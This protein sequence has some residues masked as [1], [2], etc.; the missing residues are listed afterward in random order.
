MVCGRA[1]RHPAAAQHPSGCTA[2]GRV[3]RPG[4]R[5][6]GADHPGDRDDDLL[7]RLAPRRRLASRREM[8]SPTTPLRAPATGR[9]VVGSFP[10]TSAPESLMSAIAAP[11]RS[12]A[13]SALL[14]LRSPWATSTRPAADRSAEA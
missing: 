5:A 4:D 1:V 9:P 6:V 12:A 10:L 11:E 8:T 13:F 3:D 7:H 14:G 2:A